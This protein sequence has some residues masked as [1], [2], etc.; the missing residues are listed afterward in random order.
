MKRE[1]A[2]CSLFYVVVLQTSR[3]DALIPVEGVSVAG[4]GVPAKSGKPPERLNG[5][6]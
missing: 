1:Q 5:L 4:D 6:S 2:I 3:T